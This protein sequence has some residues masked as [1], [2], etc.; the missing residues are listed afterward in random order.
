MISFP[1]NE[2]AYNY[3]DQDIMDNYA[4]L[5]HSLDSAKVTYIIFGTQPRDFTDAAQR[6]RLK[7]LNDKIIA[8]YTWHVNDNLDQ[9]STS[10]YSIKPIYAAGDGIHLNNAGHLVIM[11][12]TLKHPLFTKTIN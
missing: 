12:N 11:N 6:M 3:S 1:T 5:T 7:T 10:T 4:K 8:T 9:L 2:I